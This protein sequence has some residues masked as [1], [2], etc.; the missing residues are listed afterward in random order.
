MKTEVVFKSHVWTVE[1]L[2]DCL[3][4]EGR[5]HRPSVQLYA[6]GMMCPILES[7]AKESMGFRVGAPRSSI[8][9]FSFR[10][11][12]FCN[13]RI[14]RLLHTDRRTSFGMRSMMLVIVGMVHNC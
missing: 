8:T 9:D 14:P 11:G 4:N 7:T 12:V 2:I 1:R 6:D 5:G 3:N 13:K 10:V